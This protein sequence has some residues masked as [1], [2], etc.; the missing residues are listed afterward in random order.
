MKESL[1]F[2][3]NVRKKKIERKPI[4]RMAWP[5]SEMKSLSSEERKWPKLFIEEALREAQ[6]SFR[7]SF[8]ANASA[9]INSEIWPVSASLV[10]LSIRLSEAG[11]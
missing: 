4:S 7:K 11:E 6:C 10:A 1:A 2:N 8:T 5:A 9:Y 3:E